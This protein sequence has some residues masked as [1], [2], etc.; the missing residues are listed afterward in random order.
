VREA[1]NDEHEACR[2]HT[3]WG[4]TLWPRHSSDEA[5]C[6]GPGRVGVVHTGQGFYTRGRGRAGRGASAGRGCR[7]GG[8]C[9]APRVGASPRRDGAP[10]ARAAGGRAD[11]GGRHRTGGKGITGGGHRREE[12]VT[13]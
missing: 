4:Y 10:G 13:P 1:A 6:S 7:A 3:R 11:A 5:A 9:C 2:R 12:A 8:R